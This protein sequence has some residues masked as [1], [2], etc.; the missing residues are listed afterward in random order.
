MNLKRL[1][2]VSLHLGRQHLERHCRLAPETS[3]TSSTRTSHKVNMT[4]INIL[5]LLSDIVPPNM[6]KP[7][8]KWKALEINF[9]PIKLASYF[10]QMRVKVSELKF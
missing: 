5:C 4:Q 9:W 1:L 2:V 6:N 10:M 7:G 8:S 3:Q